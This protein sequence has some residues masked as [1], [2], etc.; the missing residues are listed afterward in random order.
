MIPNKPI[1]A[2][3]VVSLIVTTVTITDLQL[4]SAQSSDLRVVSGPVIVSYPSWDSD[5]DGERETFIAHDPIQIVI[6]LNRPVCGSGQ[7][8]LQFRTDDGRTRVEELT[9]A[10]C[11]EDG[12][13]VIIFTYE[14]NPEDGYLGEVSVLANSAH[15]ETEDG[16]VLDI[17]HGEISYGHLVDG[18][19]LRPRLRNAPGV[20]DAPYEDYV[21]GRG[22]SIFVAAEFAEDIVVNASGGPPTIGIDIGGQLRRAR[23]VESRSDVRR[24]V[25]EYVVQ[26]SDRDDDGFVWVP[27]TAEGNGSGISVPPNSSI[28]NPDGTN[29]V[30]FWAVSSGSPVSVDGGFARLPDLEIIS[31]SLSTQLGPS[32]TQKT[33]GRT[34]EAVDYMVAA[35]TRILNAGDADAGPFTVSLNGEPAWRI[36]GL[37][38]GE[39]IDIDKAFAYNADVRDFKIAVDADSEVEEHDEVSANFASMGVSPPPRL[40][41]CTPTSTPTPTFTP[42]P[43]PPT[44]TTTPLP[45]T[46]TPSPTPTLLPPTAT[47][48]I[49]PTPTPTLLPPTATPTITPTPTPTLLPPTA[50]PTITPTPTPTPLPTTATPTITP[51]PTPTQLPPIATPTNEPDPTATP[52]PP[53]NSE[54]AKVVVVEENPCDDQPFV[55][56]FPKLKY[57]CFGGNDILLADVNIVIWI[58]VGL[59]V[60]IGTIASFIV[61]RRVLVTRIYRWTRDRRD[62][63]NVQSDG[64][65]Q[66][67]ID[68][69]NSDGTD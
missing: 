49:T 41:I 63:A 50:T 2:L 16:F 57:L 66:D 29:A 10:E 54:E 33:C 26:S 67:L 37:R 6:E 30:L 12:Y 65:Q 60:I 59:L 23:Y 42:A 25:F 17:P 28:S 7:I 46:A 48:T 64:S 31:F 9:H 68:G 52:V 5:G 58:I 53:N 40:P 27:S 32:H 14:V 43:P 15:W 4:L 38:I 22:E 8:S 55:I 51:S 69:T 3:I 20:I 45:P 47:P 24:I 21:Y 13:T 62:L 36:L 56:W 19:I 11:A 39:S 1:I 34:D 61:G 44:P 18:S 35:S